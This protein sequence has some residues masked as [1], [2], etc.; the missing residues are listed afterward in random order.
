MPETL[1]SRDSS[2]ALVFILPPAYSTTYDHIVRLGYHTD[3]NGETWHFLRIERPK[4]NP[5]ENVALHGQKLSFLQEAK[6]WERSSLTL[7]GEASEAA[8]GLP[9]GTV[10]GTWC[11]VPDEAEIQCQLP[12]R[13]KG[14]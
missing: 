13:M 10:I 3:P 5:V 12:L 7:V 1:F 6:A 8:G 14:S 2:P 9:S 4:G 11:V